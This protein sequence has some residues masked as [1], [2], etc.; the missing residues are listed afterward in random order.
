MGICKL[1]LLFFLHF[2]WLAAI[3]F[4]DFFG[5]GFGVLLSLLLTS[6]LHLASCFFWSPTPPSTERE[7]PNSVSGPQL[8]RRPHPLPTSTQRHKTTSTPPRSSQSSPSSAVSSSP[9]QKRQTPAHVPQSARSLWGQP[10]SIVDA[11]KRGGTQKQ[12]KVSIQYFS[13]QAL[14]FSSSI[15]LLQ[16]HGGC[17]DWEVEWG[18]EGSFHWIAS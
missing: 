13:I 17:L 10:A 2:G 5:G 11:E 8:H 6:M 4:L 14:V 15:C 9:I 16:P 1:L 7:E 3:F 18:T 12:A